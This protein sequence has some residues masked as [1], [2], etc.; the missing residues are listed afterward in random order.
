[1]RLVS[2]IF[3][4]LV[5]ILFQ[6]VGVAFS[7]S[8]QIGVFNFPPYYIVDSN[9]EVKG[10]L[11]V[12]MLRNIMDRAGLEHSF[13]SYP[14]KRLYHNLGKGNIQIWLGTL[15]VAEYEGKTLVSPVKI[16]DINLMVYT[17]DS[18][19]VLPSSIEGL[20]GRSVITI[21][22]YN[23]GGLIQFLEDPAN[24]ITCEPAKSHDAAFMM[25]KIGRSNL[26]LDYHEPASDSIKKTDL[27]DLRYSPIQKIP[28]HLHVSKAVS[29]AD[30]IMKKLMKAY[31]E[32]KKDGK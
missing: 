8:L 11:Y 12:E 20:K 18:K 9:D 24:S 2:G 31:A 13:I 28:L 29:N 22:G 25:L 4:M 32:I 7:A 17:N 23:Y 15:G 5:F 26:L 27:P 6:G 19:T 14:P 10:G 21:F 1:M 16:A 30:E 3:L